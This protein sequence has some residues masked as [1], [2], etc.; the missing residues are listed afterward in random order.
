MHAIYIVCGMWDTM[1]SGS[2][3]RLACRATGSCHGPSEGSLNLQ[4]MAN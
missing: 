4:I 1:E 2:R 3:S